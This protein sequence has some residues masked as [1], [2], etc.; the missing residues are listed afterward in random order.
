MNKVN[1]SASILA[2]QPLNLIQ[3]IDAV[4]NAGV[5]RLHIDIMDGHYVPNLS[6]GPHIINQ[7]KRK[8][9]LPFEIH[10]MVDDCDCFIEMFTAS[11]DILIIHP[12]STKHPY[13]SLTKIKE[14]QLRTG[15][16]LNPGMPLEHLPPL[17]DMVDYILIMSVNPGFGGQDFIQASYERV[18]KVRELINA[19]GLQDKVDLA[20]DGGVTAKNSGK[21]IECG[22]NV[23]ISGSG[24]FKQ[25]SYIKAVQQLKTIA[26]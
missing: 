5:D 24:I 19:K 1:V 9:I 26:H 17:I 6:F 16:A 20:V 10:L 8:T 22:A 15:V 7:L 14:Q 13:R 23:L 25:P 12:E 11:A 2:A 18:Q 21:L 3:E 4:Q